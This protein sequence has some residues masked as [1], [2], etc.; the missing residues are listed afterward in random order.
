MKVVVTVTILIKYC[1]NAGWNSCRFSINRSE[2]LE[3]VENQCFI[4][5]RSPSLL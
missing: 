2:N 4:L 1:S 5:L 3:N